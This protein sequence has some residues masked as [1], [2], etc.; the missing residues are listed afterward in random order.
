M[1]ISLKGARQ[2]GTWDLPDKSS[3]GGIGCSAGQYQLLEMDF[4]HVCLGLELGEEESQV[5]NFFGQV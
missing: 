1:G 5:E 3:S 2:V 4:P